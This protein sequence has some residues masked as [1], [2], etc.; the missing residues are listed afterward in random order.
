MSGDSVLPNGQEVK[1]VRRSRGWTQD[2]V[3][4]RIQGRVGPF[5]K[6][7]LQN[8]E[9]GKPVHLRS[10]RLVAEELGTDVSSLLQDQAATLHN[11]PSPLTSFVGREKTLIEIKDLLDSHRLL[12]LTG[13]GGCG[14]SR[15]A[16]ELAYDLIPNYP[17]GVWLVELAPLAIPSLVP[18]SVALTLGIR[19]EQKGELTDVLLGHLRPRQTLLILDNCEHLL[20]ACAEFVETLLPACPRLR[21]LTTSR[22]PMNITGEVTYLVPPL[23]LPEAE[24][25]AYLDALQDVESVRLLVD[26]AATVRSDFSLSESNASAV[27]EICRHLD[28]IPLALELAAA[29]VRTL[30]VEEIAERLADRFHL[31]TG[32][33][34]AALSRHRT[35]RA[36]IGWSYDHLS[37]DEQALLRRLSVFAGG[38]TLPAAESVCVGENLEKSDVLDLL[39]HLVDK[40]L[41]EV[42][43]DKQQGTGR[44]RYRLLETVRLYASERLMEEKEDGEACKRHRKFYLAL[45]EE[46]DP[47]LG[48]PD[49]QVWLSRL[50]EEHDNLRRALRTCQAGDDAEA[51]IGLRLAGA[52][53]QFWDVCGYW[54]EGRAMCTELLAGT[55]AGAGSAVRAKA[56]RA[57]GKLTLLLGE[58]TEARSFFEESLT[59]SQALLHKDGVAA[60]LSELGGLA[61]HKGNF[62][63]ARDLYGDSLA[64]SR[65]LG[66]Q[67]GIANALMSLG[68]A[69]W[70]QGDYAA[71]RPLLK[72]SL[73]IW[74]EMGDKRGI[75]RAIANL[76]NLAH[77]QHKLDEAHSLYSESLA[78]FRELDEK[79]GISNVL[80]NLGNVARKQNDLAGART[81][82]EEGLVVTE[83]LADKRGRGGALQNLGNVAFMQGDYTQARV[84]YEESLA[85][86]REVGHKQ[87]IAHILTNLG[88]VARLKGLSA[89][90][91]THSEESLDI[92]RELGDKQG[93]ANALGNLALVALSDGDHAQARSLSKQSLTVCRE[94]GDMVGISERLVGLGCVANHECHANRAIRLFASGH[95]RAKHIGHSFDPS[96][97][98]LFENSVSELRG[99]VDDETFAREW[100]IGQAMDLDQAVEYALGE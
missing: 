47:E 61:L 36:L 63:E 2:D 22:E 95:E 56:L 99:R 77:A 46:A 84:L 35:L 78:L 86:Y 18:Q 73:S 45:A 11:L 54:R 65:E 68:V 69:T 67:G 23:Q 70:R 19:E 88:D 1:R 49:Q 12:T 7:T 39:S 50:K 83:E 38:W 8:I 29:R 97:L 58:A 75:A 96:I 26:R 51:E 71:A 6:R 59:V 85:I 13:A 76:G 98:E 53:G 91:R 41:V 24:H 14:K 64:I 87:G 5:S 17:D 93:T 27:V 4:Q 57:A 74:R 90:A 52:L 30:S 89:E 82:Y 72:E 3:A 16:L 48:G 79:L 32:G 33:H 55:H 21:F 80:N 60:A 34:R 92:C 31:L 43:S 28:G 15:L 40:S 94:L 25:N 62:A 42:S 20:P 100:S 10:I 66:D 44:S 9:A 81:F 37:N